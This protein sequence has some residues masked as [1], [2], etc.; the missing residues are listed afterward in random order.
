MKNDNVS[1][2]ILG[3]GNYSNVKL[4]NTVSVTGDGVPN[5]R[6]FISS[7][8]DIASLGVLTNRLFHIL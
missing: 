1:R 5:Q 8:I 6:F 7:C 3:T 4:G 2:I